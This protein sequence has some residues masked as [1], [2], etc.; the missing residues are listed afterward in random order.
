MVEPAQN[1]IPSGLVTPLAPALCQGLFLSPPPPTRL[2]PGSF[3]PPHPTPHTHTLP[4]LVANW[5]LD[6]ACN[7][8]PPKSSPCT[9][10]GIKVSEP[11]HQPCA[12]PATKATDPGGPRD[13]TWQRLVLIF[14]LLRRGLGPR[15]C[16]PAWLEALAPTEREREKRRRFLA[17]LPVSPMRTAHVS[18]AGMV[19]FLCGGMRTCSVALGT[20]G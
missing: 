7:A 1:Q 4:H 3:I 14:R 8:G 2:S 10:D 12:P 6:P 9:P 5:N 20:C 15:S 18:S 17:C 16:A 11:D 13:S 19:L